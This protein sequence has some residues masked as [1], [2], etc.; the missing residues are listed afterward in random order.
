M[1]VLSADNAESL[2]CYVCIPLNLPPGWT[3]I[4]LQR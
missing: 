2:S 4:D 3:V 1:S